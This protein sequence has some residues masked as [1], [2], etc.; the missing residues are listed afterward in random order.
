MDVVFW[1][2]CKTLNSCKELKSKD[3]LRKQ[4]EEL[5]ATFYC[6]IQY[7]RSD[8]EKVKSEYE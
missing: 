1:D 2:F 3:Y 7:M 5:W 8:Y 6:K 4:E